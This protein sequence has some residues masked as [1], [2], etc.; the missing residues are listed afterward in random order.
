MPYRHNCSLASSQL[1][2]AR[3]FPSSVT[4]TQIYLKWLCTYDLHALNRL[5]YSLLSV[6]AQRL[7]NLRI[8]QW[9][10]LSWTRPFGWNC[11]QFA[12]AWENLNPIVRSR[13]HDKPKKFYQ[14]WKRYGDSRVCGYCR[15]NRTCSSGYIR[16]ERDLESH[17]S[18]SL[19]KCSC[20]ELNTL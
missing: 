20:S 19:G 12:V 8:N 4:T 2:D 7:P 10:E 18:K 13:K 5:F 16:N 15:F 1:R 17:S 9:Q 3:V 11:A 6:A 14:W